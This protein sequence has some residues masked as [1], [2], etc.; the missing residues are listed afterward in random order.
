[1]EVKALPSGFTHRATL[2]DDMAWQEITFEQPAGKLEAIELVVSSVF[3][4][5]KYTDL[6][7]SDLEVFATGAGATASSA[8]P[9]TRS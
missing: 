8:P 1:M 9:P 7:V 3:E 4:G 5:S 6:C 2:A